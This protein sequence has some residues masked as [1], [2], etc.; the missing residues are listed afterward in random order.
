MK[1]YSAAI[2][3][4]FIKDEIKLLINLR[5]IFPNMNMDRIK[6]KIKVGRYFYV[7]K[8]ANRQSQESE[9]KVVSKKVHKWVG[10][11]IIKSF[12]GISAIQVI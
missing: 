5:L 12:L 4:Q 7:K 10:L 9:K 8:I 11:Q 6:K 3:P 2:K 1:L